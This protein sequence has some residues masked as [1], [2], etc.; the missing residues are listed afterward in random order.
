MPPS[1][2]QN[3]RDELDSLLAAY[4]KPGLP[5]TVVSIVN[6]EGTELYIGA[7]G[8]ANVETGG[9]M[10]SDTVRPRLSPTALLTKRSFQSTHAP[11]LSRR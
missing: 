11:R 10:K 4:V 8:P 6:R 7:S 2:S 1:L 9:P 3:A 5:G